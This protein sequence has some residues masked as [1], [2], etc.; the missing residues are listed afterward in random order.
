[1]RLLV[2]VML[3]A[4]LMN[5]TCG[6]SSSSDFVSGDSPNRS[7][8]EC[9][10]IVISQ[11][12]LRIRA[13]WY[14][15]SR[16]RRYRT[17]FVCNKDTFFSWSGLLLI[18]L[19]SDLMKLVVIA[20]IEVGDWVCNCLQTSPLSYIVDLCCGQGPWDYACI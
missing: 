9:W 3:I 10:V 20:N 11:Y 13:I 5:S 2:I 16:W 19:I 14:P 1:M 7:D 12:E 15:E 8:G 4:V 18:Q 6:G 17:N